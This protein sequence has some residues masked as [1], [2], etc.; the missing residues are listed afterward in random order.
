MKVKITDGGR[1]K[2]FKGTAPGDC[3]TRAISI[4]TEQDYLE[5]YNAL[6]LLSKRERPRGNNKRSSARNGMTKATSK[7]YMNDLEGW[8]WIPTMG[9]GTGCTVHL[10]EEELP[11]GRLICAVSKHWCAVI[12]GVVHDAFDPTREGTRCV[13]GYWYKIEDLVD[14]NEFL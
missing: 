13:Y 4:A 3:V 2:Y 12:D 14:T 9:I 11:G 7:R 5:V 8:D 1:S 6:N 10:R